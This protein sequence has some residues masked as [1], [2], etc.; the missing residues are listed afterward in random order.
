MGRPGADDGGADWLTFERAVAVLL[1]RVPALD[2]EEI[3]A[4]GA[5]GRALAEPVRSEV[6]HPP[7]D[8]SAM[9]GFAVRA[10][11]VTGASADEPVVLPVTGE[12]PAGGFPDGPLE[13][14]TAVRVA[15]GAPVPGGTDS[16]V[17]IEHTDGGDGERV[18]IADDADARRHVR[19]RG[20][21]VR[22]GQLLLE[23]GDEV[24][25]AAA[26]LLAMTGRTRVRV[27]RRPRV[28]VL[29][30]G[31]ELVPAERAG[32]ALEGR[33]IVD[34]NSPALA[35]LLRR[36]GAEPVR[37]GLAPDEPDELRRRLE[38][39]DDCDAIVSSGGVSVGE[40]DH[41]H[42]VLEALGLERVFWRVKIRPGSPFTFGLLPDGRPCF[43]LPGNPVSAVVTAETL[44]RP[45][46]RAMA[47]HA[48]TRRRRIA[49]RAAEEMRTRP[50][51]TYFLRVTL[52]EGE[53]G[54]DR[55]GAR[56]GDGGGP[57]LRARPTG[58]QGSGILTSVAAADALLVVPEGTGRLEAGARA[59]AIPLRA[60]A[61]PGGGTDGGGGPAGDEAR[62]G[63]GEAG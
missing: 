7:W 4:A 53:A 44:L 46:L 58:P 28:G 35:A 25:P 55:D 62:G 8:N 49:V 14:G 63:A 50:D 11:D 24:T 2:A 52:E 32:E 48:A 56:D 51:L 16:V 18:R 47:G 31:D 40:R 42:R 39:A 37:L 60:W 17:R 54:G 6:D 22:E 26:G 5:V 41:V 30:S 9:D 43:G 19:R 57:V 29:A 38:G 59:E 36:I 1:E 23:A 61:R 13:P 21:D 34:T 15:T 3:A 45:A 12:V 27:G 33:K 20:E 10:A